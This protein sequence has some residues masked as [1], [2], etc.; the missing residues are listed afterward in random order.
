MQYATLGNTGLVVSRLA[1]GAMTFG[2]GQLVPGISN[3]IDQAAA[4]QMVGRALD[5]GINLF[6]TADAYTEE[7]QK[8]FWAKPWENGGMKWRSPLK[9]VFASV[10]Q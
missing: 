10:R 2:T 6:D 5:V 7:S 8:L 3:N 9:L 1:F 4:D